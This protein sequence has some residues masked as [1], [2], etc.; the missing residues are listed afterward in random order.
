MKR[1]I[2][3]FTVSALAAGI[4]ACGGDGDSMNTG[5]TGTVSFGVTDA[6]AMEFTDVTISFTGISLKP[7]DGDWVEFT[8]DEPKSWNLLELQG[9]LSESLIT[10]EEVPAGQYSEL[11]LKI[12]TEDSD[13]D[14]D[15]LPDSYVITKNE[16]GIQKTLAV[17]SGEQSGLKL[18]GEFDVVADTATDFTID[19]DVRKSLVNPQGDSLADYLLKPSLRLVNNLEVGSI[20]GDVDYLTIQSTRLNDDSLADCAQDYAGSVYVYQGADVAPTDINVT[21]D[22]G[23]PLM[24]VPVTDEDNDGMYSYV[25]A[26]LP[27]GEYTISYSCQL[28]DNE[29]DDPLEFQGTQ[30]VTVVADTDTVADPIPLVP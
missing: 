16:P 29:L 6:P 19:F 15:S 1:S 28:D 21:T 3:L 17:P 30:N 25:A 27:E 26:F 11:R 22:T 7:V 24:A 2:Q 18:K 4:A 10:D 20:T 9:G 13:T 5:S 23:G 8:F 14:Q 12:N